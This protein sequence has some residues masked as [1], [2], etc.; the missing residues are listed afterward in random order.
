LVPKNRVDG[1]EN[2]HM[3]DLL[4]GEPGDDEEIAGDPFF[5]RYNFPQASGSG[6]DASSSSAESSSDTEGPLS[7]THIK[8]RQPGHGDTL[9]SPRSPV[10][11]VEVCFREAQ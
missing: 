5:Q 1:S 2:Y 11:S 4:A 6:K 10:P 9:P 3:A 8:G 7:P